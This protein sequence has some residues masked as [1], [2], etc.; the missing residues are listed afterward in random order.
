MKTHKWG[1]TPKLLST[2]LP[3]LTNLDIP[4][5]QVPQAMFLRGLEVLRSLSRSC[6]TKSII[7]SRWPCSKQDYLKTLGFL[8]RYQL[9]H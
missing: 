4:W 7:K 5:P 1:D 8:A 6:T 9:I 3:T 2:Q